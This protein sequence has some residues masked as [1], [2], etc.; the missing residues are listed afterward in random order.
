MTSNVFSAVDVTDERYGVGMKRLARAWKCIA[1]P[2]YFDKAQRSSIDNGEGINI[3]KFLKPKDSAGKEN[4]GNCEY[5]YADKDCV[6]WGTLIDGMPNRHD[7]ER[8]YKSGTTYAI[9]VSVPV[10]D[11]TED[12]IQSVRV[13][14]YDTNKEVIF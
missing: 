4:G 13:F 9:C 11:G 1:T 14:H 10:D 6:F 5:Y 12:T 7:F 2:E 8:A 3:F